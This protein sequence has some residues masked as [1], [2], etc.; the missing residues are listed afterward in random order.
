MNALFK[1]IIMERICPDGDR[2]LR[3]HADDP[4][5]ILAPLCLC[6]GPRTADCD[7][8]LQIFSRSKVMTSSCQHF[9]IYCCGRELDEE[10]APKQKPANAPTPPRIRSRA[11]RM[12]VAFELSACEPESS[13][14][15][16]SC[17]L[18]ME[19]HCLLPSVLA[20]CYSALILPLKLAFNTICFVIPI[21]ALRLDS[22][23]RRG[24]HRTLPLRINNI[25][26]LPKKAHI[27]ILIF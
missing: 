17:Q 3:A 2:F 26:T 24:P 27:S 14:A 9:I 5:E 13:V 20:G 7:C 1:E 18:L 15:F 23:R 19:R 11:R 22:G 12:S 6:F 4:A 16:L 10:S 21:N 25:H 8:G